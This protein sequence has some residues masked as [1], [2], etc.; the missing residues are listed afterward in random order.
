MS[1]VWVASLHPFNQYLLGISYVPGAV[2]GTTVCSEQTFWYKSDKAP[3]QSSQSSWG[4]VM[5]LQR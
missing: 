3:W 5:S 1:S 2:L 4:V